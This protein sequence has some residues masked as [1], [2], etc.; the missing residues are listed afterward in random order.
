MGQSKSKPREKK[1]EEKKSTT[2]LVTKSKE[3][4][5]E[6]EAK[7]SDKES[8]PAESLLFGTGTSKHSRPSSSSEEGL[9]TATPEMLTAQLGSHQGRCAPLCHLQ[10]QECLPSRCR[11]SGRLRRYRHARPC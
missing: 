3:K 5:M 4:V 8:Q 1:E 7:Q 11:G 10:P 9:E 6:K 2:T